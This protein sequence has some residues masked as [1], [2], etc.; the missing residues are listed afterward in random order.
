LKTPRQNCSS[1]SAPPRQPAGLRARLAEAEETLRAIRAGEVDSVVVAGKHGPQVFTLEGAGHAYRVLIESM[2]EGALT[3]TADKTILYAN[4]CFAQM[5]KCPLEQ[6]TGSSFRRFLS[7][8]DRATLRPLIKRADKSGSKIQVLLNAGDGS[9]MPVQISIRRLPKNG[10]TRAPIGLVVTDMT[11]AR[12]S[13]ELLRTLTHRVVQAQETERG[14]VALEL[15]DTITQMLCAILVRSEVLANKLPARHRRA[16]REAIKLHEIIGRTVE[17]VDR[18]SRNL[19]PS[20]LDH[21]GL[22]AGLHDTS[23]EFTN[24]TGVSVKLVCVELT[25]RLPADTE[26]ALYRILQETLKNVE[27]HARARHVTVHLTKPGDIV[28]LTIHDDGKG[29]DPDHYPAGQKGRGGFGLLGMRERATYLG[30]ILKVK[31]VRSAGTEIEIRIPL[32]PGVTATN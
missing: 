18:I 3:L 30:G 5:V 16:K 14:R 26:L 27:K 28:Q 13:E 1:R 25:P 23:T 4:Q 9:Q 7:A 12:R 10:F 32:P 19:R 31:S 29:F 24:R 2:N 6:V 22:V 17:E 15:H 21:L 20:V 11:A 8:E